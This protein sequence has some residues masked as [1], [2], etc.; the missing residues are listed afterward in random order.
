MWRRSISSLPTGRIDQIGQLPYIGDMVKNAAIRTIAFAEAKDNFS[1]FISSVVREHLPQIVERSRGQ[2]AALVL[3]LADMLPA[4]AACRF[5]ARL[6]V[7]ESVVATLPQFG[8]VA[9]GDDIE[10][11]IDAL[12][13]ELA[14]YCE[15]FFSDFDFYRHTDRVAHLPWLLR[16]ALT[17]PQD[18]TSLLVEERES[19]APAPAPEVAVAASR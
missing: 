5:D 8:L 11:A 13:A 15:D 2:E 12:A 7:A 14:D 17:P 19:P 1:G 4:L 3:P 9:R 16:F 6:S 10:S 18:R